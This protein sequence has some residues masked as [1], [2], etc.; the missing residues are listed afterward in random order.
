MDKKSKFNTTLFVWLYNY[1]KYNY[2][3]TITNYKLLIT[4]Y[5]Y[6]YTTFVEE[7][8]WKLFKFIKVCICCVYIHVR[9]QINERRSHIVHKQWT[10]QTSVLERVLSYHCQK[11]T[12]F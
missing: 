3:I 10:L 12:T 2:T 5:K 9:S 6:N 1:K 11:P 8:T 7:M 4:N